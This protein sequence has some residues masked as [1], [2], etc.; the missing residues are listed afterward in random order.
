MKT[1]VLKQSIIALL[2]L[3][4]VITTAQKN[5]IDK[6]VARVGNEYILKSEIESMYMQENSGTT[7]SNADMK[8]EILEQLLIQKLLCAE[9][10]LDSIDVNITD[11]D[12]QRAIDQRISEMVQTIGS[13][14]R[15]EQYFGQPIK[16][17]VEDMQPSY[18]AMLIAQEMQKSIQ[19]NIRVTPAEV[20]AFY[21]KIPKDSLI[22]IPAKYVLQQ[23]VVDPT[24]SE[25]EKERCR[26]RLRDFR[27]RVNSGRSSFQTLAVLYSEDPGNAAK[28][29][30]LGYF[31]K[32]EMVKEF[33]E[34]AFSLKNDKVS[35]IVET[36]YGFHII[37]LIDR[38][39][40]KINARHILLIPKASAEEKEEALKRLDT[41]RT[42]V[43][44]NE[45]TFDEAARYFSM[46]KDTRNNGGLVIDPESEDI[47]LPKTSI[48]GEMA[49]VVNR[50]N[51][52]EISA[53]F[54]DHDARGGIEIHKIVKIKEYFPA[55]IANLEEDWVIFERM[56]LNE[57][58]Q[59]ALIKW[60]EE[61]QKNTYISIDDEYKDANFHYDGWIK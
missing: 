36:E 21:K 10:F 43:I 12:V 59:Q 16:D 48:S 14:E 38:K 53:P 50:M 18:R 25:T 30:E 4:P 41:I 54:T 24:I 11:I 56:L 44:N 37:Q 7:T 5:V 60:V 55:H 8:A 61:K 49:R 9:A 34:V 32:A 27:E 20:R 23:I 58:K 19:A 15:L 22:E 35:K 46:D 47:R 1:N 33:S 45:L 13:E 51:V 6:I 3:M 57:K 29:G 2:L 17:L 52:G 26:E 42:M 28:G 31:G 40:E 39:G